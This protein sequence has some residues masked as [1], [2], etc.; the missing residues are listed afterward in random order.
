MH[1]SNQNGPSARRSRA[2]GG[3][4]SRR[5][6]VLVLAGSILSAAAIAAVVTHS[7]LTHDRSL[8]AQAPAGS[9]LTSRLVY[10]AGARTWPNC[11]DT[12]VPVGTVL[13]KMDSPRPTGNG[14]RFY[15]EISRSG[16]VIK[17]ID[18]TGSI[19]VWANNVTIENSVIRSNS[20]WGIN[21]RP[22]YHGLRVIHC[23]IIGLPGRGPDAGYE[24]YGVSS[25]SD[26]YIAVGWDNISGFAAGISLGE[27]YIHDNYVHNEQAFIPAA[28]PGFWSHDN[29]FISDGGAR[30]TIKHNT[31]LDQVPV[32]RG[33]SS[34]IGLYYDSAP[35]RYT[36]VEDN[37]MAGGAYCLYPGGGPSSSHVV[38][39]D[40]VFSTLYHRSCGYYGPVASSY[41]HYGSG[42][43]WFGNVWA[44]GP[45]AGR[46]V[47]PR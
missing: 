44:D 14:G 35:V 15:T 22:G 40:N 43:K 47:R 2:P 27:G 26:G 31:M 29:A 5:S 6:L 36:L 18:L 46:A 37:F 17:D 33:A 23:T 13:R 42:N 3:H 7:N 20:W 32:N 24:D 10:K 12:G 21:L 34:S 39:E 28:S 16:T 19:D 4:W 38:I 1:Q 25:S 9:C 11:T 30:L 41:W 8:S 45:R